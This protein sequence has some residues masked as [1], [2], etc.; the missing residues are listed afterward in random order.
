MRGASSTKDERLF[1]RSARWLGVARSLAMYYGVPFRARRMAR[2]YS[3]FVCPDALCF[4]IGA[5]V[6]NRIRCWRR[7]G[8]TVVAIEPQADFVRLLR[9]LYGGDDRVVIVPKA[10]GRSPGRARL[11][12]S[13][14]TPT[15]TTLSRDWIDEVRADPSFA[16]IE[17]CEGEEVEITTLDELVAQHGEPDFVKI[18]VE[19][20]EAEVLAGLTRPVRALSFEYLPA[21]RERALECVERL[22][23]LADYRFNWSVGE[24]HVLGALDW[25]DAA[26]IRAHLRALGTGDGSGDV[27]AERAG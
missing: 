7:L 24:S 21:A 17:W 11:L 16:G 8:A 14:R 22:A 1:G 3:R 26:G 19:G 12:V 15:V 5:H 27:Y 23:A 2:F 9:F 10:V 25:L 13:P 18:D 4:D 20:F 6:G